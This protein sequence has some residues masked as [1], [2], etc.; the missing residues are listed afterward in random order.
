MN[1]PFNSRILSENFLRSDK[2]LAR[3][4]IADRKT[5]ADLYGKYKLSD[6]LYKLKWI[7]PSGSNM[8]PSV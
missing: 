5:H 8:C 2:R 4:A 3:Y 6:I 1:V 7:A